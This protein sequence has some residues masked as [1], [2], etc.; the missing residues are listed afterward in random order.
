[1]VD[2]FILDKPTGVLPYMH[3]YIQHTV[4]LNYNFTFPRITT[5]VITRG[6]QCIPLR[7]CVDHVS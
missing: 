4:P 7:V 3:T 1:M 6:I 5:R 2:L